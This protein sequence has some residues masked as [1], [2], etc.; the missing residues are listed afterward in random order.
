MDDGIT[1]FA[2]PRDDGL[3]LVRIEN[4]AGLAIEA[5]PNGTL[6]AITHREPRGTI[7]INQ[8]LGAPTGGG[9]GRILLRTGGGSPDIATIAGSGSS[10][11][12]GHVDNAFVYEGR[13]SGLAY[14]AVLALDPEE[15]LWFWR[16]T[17]TNES[18]E[19]IP[20]DLISAQDVGLGG[21]GFLMGSEAYASQYLDHHVETHPDFGPVVMSRQNLDQ[22]GRHPWLVQ[23]C[24]N[25]ATAFATDAMQ[26]FGPAF[27]LS[28]A[29]TLP[30]G[31]NLPSMVLQHEV[32]CPAIQST[33]QT[34]APG[35]TATL[36]FFARFIPDH[37]TA[38]GPDDLALVAGIAARV[39]TLADPA[40]AARPAM[41]SL[42]ETAPLAHAAPFSDA[43]IAARYPVRLREEKEDGTLLS[44]FVADGAQNRHVVTAA[45]EAR[46]ARRHGS[47]LRSGDSL[48]LDEKTLSSTAWMQGVFAA[49]LTIG[50]TSFH[51]LFSVS[52]DPYGLTR[53]SGLR[54]L[55][56]CGAGWELLGVPSLFEMGLSDCRWIYA[57]GERIVTVHA[58]AAGDEAA[59]Q[60]RVDVEG[61]PCRFLVIGHLVLGEREF[62]QSGTV[63]ID[64]EA[65]RAS[66]TPGADWLWGRAYPKARMD[67]VTATP[68]AVAAVGGDELAYPDGAARGAPVVTLLSHPTH[69]L[70]L[71]VTGSMTSTTEANRLADRYAAGRSQDEALA[72]AHRFWSQTTRDMRLKGAHPDIEAAS[73][74]LPWLAHDAIVHLTVPHGLEQYSGAAWGTRDV[75][76]GPVEFLLAMRHDT[77]VHRILR[78][79]FAEQH[80]KNADWPQWFML[81]PYSDIRAGDAHG[82]VIIW[83]LKALADYIE[84]SGDIGILAEKV[85]WRGGAAGETASIAEHVAALI[86]EAERRFIPGTHLI[87]YGEGD[88]NDSLQPHDPHL[89]DWMVS[90]WTAGLLHE[91]IVRYASILARA[92]GNTHRG[93]HDEA[94]RLERLAEAIRSDFNRHLVSGGITAGYALFDTSGHRTE[95]LLHPSDTR[96]GLSY[97]LIAMTQS[98]LGG[99][100]GED[101]TV[102]QLAAIDA[103]LTFPDGLRLMDKP[104][105]Y[106]G[107]PETLFRRAESAAFFGRE[108][109]LM[110]VH[111]HLRQS[112]VLAK[113]G[114]ADALW[115]A[116]AL[117]NPIRVTEVL[118]QATLRQRNTYFSSSDAAFA[119][120]YKA[121]AD[122]ESLKDGT[123]AVDGGWRTYSSGPGI[124][125][126]LLVELAL[127]LRRGQA[128]GKVIPRD[129]GPVE[130]IWTEGSATRRLALQ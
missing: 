56:D 60:W 25:G 112:E 122:W 57:L 1:R 68:D 34:L 73:L 11:A 125:T 124:F 36:T 88:W 116:I 94:R 74:L 35:E 12:F 76:Q 84:A 8:V 78:A 50:N 71:A 7:M 111:A 9:I 2:T 49:Q 96:T 26:L 130:L 51:K 13:A 66:F 15:A 99:L 123:M 3:G 46:I 119:D 45:K 127:G 62:E 72:P 93:A 90:S 32:A 102:S 75:C 53:A 82:D 87:R 43:R 89:R 108:I 79:L 63:T 41:H 39:A 37:P 129:F 110:Y 115:D 21:R 18:R 59:L 117:A 20:F 10:G 17:V 103:S 105:K 65:K 61:E 31:I 5:L 64:P 121:S 81:P 70:V 91:Q 100:V 6:F 77:A 95:L 28:G 23:G 109:G 40:A 47:I 33:A 44:F 97:S 86:A 114:A 24:L 104:V 19:A 107:G 118:N 58:V 69:A 38:S 22:G 42:L 83:P 113:L 106:A 128:A 80:R 120:R 98:M 27:R 101:E 67:L 52:R 48:M 29:I 4:A 55:I 16:I 126:R 92:D 14:R 54:I 30:F 85:G